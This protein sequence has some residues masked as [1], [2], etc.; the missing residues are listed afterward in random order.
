MIFSVKYNLLAI[1][2]VL[3]MFGSS[4]AKSVVYTMSIQN[5]N[6]HRSVDLSTALVK[7]R[8]A[9]ALKVSDS[10]VKSQQDIDYIITAELLPMQHENV[11]V[12]FISAKEKGG[13]VALPVSFDSEEDL[14]SRRQLHY[15]VNLNSVVS[16]EK[17]K[18][19]VIVVD[20]VY[21]HGMVP[22]PHEI[23]QNDKQKVVWYGYALMPSKYK[24]LKQ[25]VKIML[26]SSTIDSFTE[27]GVKSGKAI[28]YGPYD[29]A[30]ES[31]D[32]WKPISVHF[33]NN[34]PFVTVTNLVR[35]FWVSHWGGN[36]AV[37]EWYYIRHDGAKLKGQFSRIDYALNQMQL[38]QTAVVNQ[39]HIDLPAHARDVYY[40]D[41][42]G[43]VSTSTFKPSPGF[44]SKPSS[45]DLRPRYP[46]YGGWLYT[47]MQG[48][49]APLEDFVKEV[50][51]AQDRF[52]FQAPFIKGIEN[53][54]YNNVTV[55]IVLP[56]G[57]TDYQVV[58]P[59]KVNKQ[60]ESKTF[61]FVDTVGRPT[62][63]LHMTDLCDGHEQNFQV[64]YTFD[65]M[66]YLRKPLVLSASF[67]LVF[68]LSIV[69]GRVDL[70]IS[71]NSKMNKKMQ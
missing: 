30:V 38:H 8:R 65:K 34:S 67:F 70:S 1:V 61:T 18:Q 49:N 23:E 64:L 9:I 58:L 48:Y 71:S 27:G 33:V 37:E 54:A 15:K 60:W 52:V 35:E 69:Y 44:S 5:V 29:E 28:T 25:K 41:D 56:E 62:I 2:A 14:G 26:A 20:I 43:N 4:I 12:S 68:L 59:F 13:K 53:A 7:E 57:A 46:L 17:S 39:V 31:K 32:S 51:D 16:N 3:Y 10:Q 6:V 55:K 19:P 47:W 22:M 45:L 63:Y 66:N 24:T 42:V 50:D 40:K 36:L 11:T 21:T